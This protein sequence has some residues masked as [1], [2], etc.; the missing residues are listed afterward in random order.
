[1]H[2]CTLLILADVSEISCPQ[3]KMPLL[4]S[5]IPLTRVGRNRCH[6]NRMGDCASLDLCLLS[7][8]KRHIIFHSECGSGVIRKKVPCQYDMLNYATTSLFFIHVNFNRKTNTDDPCLGSDGRRGCCMLAIEE[9]RPPLFDG[10]GEMCNSLRSHP[11]DS[12]EMPGTKMRV[13]VPGND[14]SGAKGSN[15]R[16]KQ[17]AHN[18]WISTLSTK[19]RKLICCWRGAII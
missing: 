16:R 3:C 12:W 5:T 11:Q 9:G 1:M 7:F 2:V 10:T 8:L 13:P 15:I 19:L 6:W 18:L 17:N 4:G 14:C